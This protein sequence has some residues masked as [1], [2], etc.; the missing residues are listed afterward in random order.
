MRRKLVA[1]LMITV[2]CLTALA[3]CSKTEVKDPVSTTPDVN[4]V[5]SKPEATQAPEKSAEKIKIRVTRWGDTAPAAEK[6]LIDDFNKTNDKNI[7]V[8]F[9]VVPGDGYGDRL[10]TSFSSGDGYD[11]FLS[12]EG[13]FFKWVD[14]G[15][16]YPMDDL[17]AND[18]EYVQPVSDSLMKMG[19][20][21]GKQ[22]YI[23]AGQNPICLYYNRDLFDKMGVAY[24]T[25]D[26]TWDDLFAAA[27][28][29]TTK[30]DDGTYATYGFNAQSWAY[31]VLTYLQS[32]GLDMISADGTTAEGY[33]NSPE[34]AAAL[35]KYFAMAEEPN[36]V[37]PSSA[38]LSTFGSATAMMISGNLGMFISGGWDVTPLR[39]AKCNYGTA[40]IPGNHAS[41][42]CA[43]GFA[44]G[45]DCKNPEAA[46]EVVKLLTN[47]KASQLRE[48]L[49][50]ALPT[51][52][53]GMQA[54]LDTADER[55]FGLIRTLE[56]GVQPIGMR[57][58]L[59]SKINEVTGKI[60]ERII[61][62][63]GT[64]QQILDDALATVSE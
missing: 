38:D 32:Y 12:G 62:K 18:K 35:D 34:V 17:I 11:V 52:K 51:S 31:A 49:E 4:E 42:V 45:A 22:S 6:Q 29:L 16:T 25:D 58:V 59:G 3:G 1:L 5:T 57:S 19:N 61:Y 30:N 2:L 36:K 56:Y 50:K 26:W 63:D 15:L 60:F 43:A 53:E 21:N 23:V 54:F 20:I 10:T 28:K 41:Y 27:T 24:P 48:E 8:I 33:L 64:T 37:S 14:K 39:D 13:D 55:D 47:Q 44:I 40:L 9:D 7:E 46:W